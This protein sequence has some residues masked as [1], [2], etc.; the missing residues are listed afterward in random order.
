VPT[1][2]TMQIE[3]A[4][5]LADAQQ[6]VRLTVPVGTTAE[7][8]VR[9]SGLNAPAE[10]ALGVFSRRIEPDHVLADGDRV[11]IYRPLMLDP[12]DAR[13]RRAQRD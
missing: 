6:V 9:L 2:E 8:A 13:R 1:A 11:E 4:F 7:Q 10:L 3:V 5:A 12:M